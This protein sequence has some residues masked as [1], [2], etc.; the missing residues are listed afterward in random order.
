MIIFGVA[1]VLL[2]YFLMTMIRPAHG[3]RK[4]RIDDEIGRAHV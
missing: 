4:N 1:Y 3:S 2:V